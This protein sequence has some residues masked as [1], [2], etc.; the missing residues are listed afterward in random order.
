[1]GVEDSGVRGELIADAYLASERGLIDDKELRAQVLTIIA[2]STASF[3]SWCSALERFPESV[4][5]SIANEWLGKR[6]GKQ[7]RVATGEAFR[8]LRHNEERVDLDRLWTRIR[9]WRRLESSVLLDELVFI[10]HSA[11]APEKLDELAEDP[12]LYRRASSVLSGGQRNGCQ[13]TATLLAL[14]G[15]QI[16]DTSTIP[17]KCILTALHAI[18]AKEEFVT[19]HMSLVGV[20]WGIFATLYGETKRYGQEAPALQRLVERRKTPSRDFELSAA[21]LINEIKA[22]SEA[23]DLERQRIYTEDTP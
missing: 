14:S 11:L 19:D 1:M 2:G 8:W 23:T 15:R 22:L 5:A 17:I 10:A 13:G 4:V 20:D 18:S 9:G 12:D 3:S 6:T 16:Q 21:K 7:V